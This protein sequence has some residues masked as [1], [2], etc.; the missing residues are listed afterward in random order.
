MQYNEDTSASGY[1]TD[2]FEGISRRF[3]DVEILS[4]S[5]VNIVA[6]AKR[7]GRWW[8]LKGLRQE[9]ACESVYSQMLRKELEVVM[10]LQHP[11]IPTAI[12][13]EHVE[14]IGECIVM[15]Y[16]DGVTLTEW[17]S[18]KHERKVCRRIAMKLVE[19]VA[20]IHMNGVVH[21][22]LKPDNILIARN[23]E[24]VHVIDFGLADTDSHAVLKQPAGTLRYMSP[25]QAT[26]AVADVRNDIYSLGI[27]FNKMNL[28]YSSIVNKC[29]RPIDNRYQ[30]IDAL[31]DDMRLCNRKLRWYAYI[32]LV[33]IVMALLVVVIML[34]IRDNN[35]RQMVAES[36]IKQNEMSLSIDKL[37]D[38]L[39]NLSVVHQKMKN[40]L[41]ETD[42]KQRRVHDAISKGKTVI[43]DALKSTGVWQQ[44]DTLSAKRYCKIDMVDCVMKSGKALNDYLEQIKSDFTGDEM[45]EI[46]NALAVYNGERINFI[47]NKINKIK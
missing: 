11:C 34:G 45:A 44:L 47:D 24:T 9:L 35:M 13:L 10:K 36:E 42:A 41:K 37:N 3:T 16:V 25:E 29:L 5:D 19:V 38:S 2:P 23:G 31:L 15:E 8:L 39:A 12:G 27:I 20:Y 43:D 1:L 4:E 46:I 22:D 40:E 18:E 14:N 28:G 32:I 33:C 26:T 6:K 21:R 7:Y 17:L 30:N